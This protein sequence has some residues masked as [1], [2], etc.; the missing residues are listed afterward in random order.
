MRFL[1][2]VFFIFRLSLFSAEADFDYVFVGTSPISVLE[3]LYRSYCGSRVLMVEAESTIG[4]AWKAIDICGIEQV[5]MGCHQ[6]SGEIKLKRFLEDYVGCDLVPMNNPYRQ[7]KPVQSAD[8]GFYFSQGC[9]EL[10]ARL[11]ELIEASNIVLLLNH[12][13]KSVYLNFEQSLA[14][15]NVNDNYVTCLKLVITPH[16]YFEIEN[17]PLFPKPTLSKHFHLYLRIQDASPTRFTYLN[18]FCMGMSRVIN[19][20]PFS[21][22][23]E[24]TGEQLIVIQTNDQ[25]SFNKPEFYLQELKKKGLIDGA[26]RLIL[27]T[28]YIYEQSHL[29]I[30]ALKSCHQKAPS[31]FEILQTDAIWN[32]PNNTEKWEKKFKKIK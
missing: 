26:A 30:N 3:A 29:N 25:A 8:Q 32:I 13:L 28:G 31:F 11:Y 23:L 15:V 6:I 5:D 17:F 19:L 21:P 9:Y 18:G 12:K 1:L 7:N 27:H 10:S 4:G 16:S 24:A 2:F 20:T 14:R 22:G